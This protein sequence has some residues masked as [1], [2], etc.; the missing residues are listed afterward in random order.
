MVLL[1]RAILVSAGV[2]LCLGGLSGTAPRTSVATHPCGDPE[3]FGDVSRNGAIDALDAFLV[4]RGSAG[5]YLD[6]CFP[7]DV[8]CDSDIDSVDALKILRSHAGLAYS[9]IEPCPDIGTLLPGGQ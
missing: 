4:L 5:F 2:I 6:A 1:S 7:P 8:D 9:Q 3:L